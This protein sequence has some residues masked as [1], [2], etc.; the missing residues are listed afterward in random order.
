MQ[1]ILPRDL[2]Q[3]V[4]MGADAVH[5]ILPLDIRTTSH[6]SEG[7]VTAKQRAENVHSQLALSFA[8]VFFVF[9]NDGMI[10]V[11]QL[12]GAGNLQERAEPLYG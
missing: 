12:A 4:A 2:A 7:R 1:T 9:K 3:L 6:I 10:F 8:C 11:P 5:P